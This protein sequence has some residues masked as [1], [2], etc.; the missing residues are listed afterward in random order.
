MKMQ[1]IGRDSRFQRLF[2]L[3]LPQI[4][5]RKTF[6]IDFSFQAK[7]LQNAEIRHVCRTLPFFKILYIYFKSFCIRKI[8]KSKLKNEKHYFLNFQFS[9]KLF[10]KITTIII[11]NSNNIIIYI[12]PTMEK[13]IK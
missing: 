1:I 3:F 2:G 11:K 6:P 8:Q 13:Q 7:P 4:L 9:E 12:Y 10:P 5:N